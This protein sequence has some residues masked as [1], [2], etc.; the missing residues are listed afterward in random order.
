M[1]PGAIIRGIVDGGMRTLT[2]ANA[3][4]EAQRALFSGDDHVRREVEP[5]LRA[6]PVERLRAFALMSGDTLRW[7]ARLTPEQLAR[8]TAADPLP[9]D[10][11]PVMRTLRAGA[12]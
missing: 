1:S 5:W 6:T 8:A 12:R 4:L 10:A 2:E 11:G 7:L 3:L 9:E